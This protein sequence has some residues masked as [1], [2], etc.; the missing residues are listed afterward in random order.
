MASELS[1]LNS[2]FIGG[3][4]RPAQSGATDA[5]INPA[6]GV[7]IGEVPASD[8]ADVDAAVS[9]AAAAFPEWSDLSPRQRSEI[10]HRVADVIDDNID[11]LS[12]IEC[13]NVGKPV[14][15][16]EFE[17]DLTKDNW[18]FFASA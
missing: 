8:A 4:W 15:I 6:T 10:M 9:A 16:V 17:M 11:E 12:R 7:A 5:V 1:S 13:E 18:R 2:N 3:D 14:G